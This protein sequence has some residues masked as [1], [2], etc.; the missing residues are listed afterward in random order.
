MIKYILKRL[1]MGVTAMLAV[2]I[3]TFFLMN[4]VP[5]GPFLS[6]KAPSAAV[7]EQ[8]EK[9]Y[10]LD[11][12][13]TTQYATWL[14]DILR[15]DLGVSFKMQKNRSVLTIITEMFPNSLKVGIFAMLWA[16]FAGIVLGCL[17]AYQRGRPVDSVL[18]VVTTMGVV[19]PTFVTASIL[20]VVFAGGIWNVVPSIV[21]S[22]ARWQAYLLPCFTLG[23][24]P[25]CNI[26]RYTRSSML[27]ALGQEYI[28]TAYAKGLPTGLIVFKHALRNA[29]IPVI[30]YIGPM[31][32][33]VLTGGF[34]VES[35][36]GIP[37]LGRY[38]VQSISNRD[39][40]L[41][42]GTTIFLAAFVIVMTFVVDVLYRVIDPRIELA[43]EGE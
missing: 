17:S 15:G 19:L 27:D 39:Y 14:K 20:L 8:L 36:F 4:L 32:A 12:P 33:Y 35:V 25:M 1:V 26:A 30:S 41:I 34:V 9:K 22:N 28:R 40:P 2:S 11:K 7:L 29:L 24:N 31:V 18:R 16:I 38:F 3:I 21:G 42:M 37:G 23:L 5:G 13:L 6:E 43:K 10:G